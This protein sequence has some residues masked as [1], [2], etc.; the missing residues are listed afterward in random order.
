MRSTKLASSAAGLPRKSWRRRLSSPMR[1]S[2]SASRSAADTGTVN[3]SSPAASAS[4]RSRRAQ[5]SGAVWT[6]SSS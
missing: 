2:S 1:S 3:G 5:K 6:A 4:S